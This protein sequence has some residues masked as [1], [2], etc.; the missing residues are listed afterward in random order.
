MP[1][2]SAAGCRNMGSHSFPKDP[3]LRKLWETA[4]GKDNFI[5]SKHSRLCAE[6]F[7]PSDYVEVCSTTGKN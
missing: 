4:T 6:H 5:A 2:C 3:K 7:K 1:R